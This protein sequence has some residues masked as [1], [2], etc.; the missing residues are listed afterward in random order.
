[1]PTRTTHFI[2]N[3]WLSGSSQPL[4]SR[5]PLTQEILWQGESASEIEVNAAVSSASTACE[6]W[7]NCPLHQRIAYLERFRNEL[8]AASNSLAEAISKEIGKP[9]WESKTEVQAMINKI[10]ISIE[11]YHQRCPE[12]VKENPTGTS[13]TRHKPHGILAIFGPFNFPG[14]LPNGHIIPG[15]LAGNTIIFK[16]SEKAPLVAEITMHCWQKADLPP[17]VINMIQGGRE[18]GTLLS[19]HPGIDGLC[20]TGSWETGCFL[21]EAFAKHPDKILALEM[22]GNNPLV[23]TNVTNIEA[24]VYTIIQ[25]AYLTAGQ[26]CSCARR[27]IILEGSQGDRLVEELIKS[28]QKIRVGPYTDNPEPFM[29]PVISQNA[30]H[31]LLSAQSALKKE[32][33]VPLCEMKLMKVDT[34]LLTPGLIDVTAVS[35]SFDQEIFGPLLQLRRVRDFDAAIIEANKTAY[36]LT[37]GLLSDQEDEFREFYRRVRAGVINW[38]VPLTGAS[39][40]APFGGVGKSGNHRPSGFYAADYCS[41]PVASIEMAELKMPGTMP[42]GMT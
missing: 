11:A 10:P 14:H 41:Y 21:S 39:S 37:A 7:A 2:N 23:V 4:I 28:I 3:Q 13:I 6:N 25:S 1:M 8:S 40:A 27:L 19:K 15:L 16:P 31:Q 12:I 20:F 32:G 29:G 24:A 22:G 26:R 17:G 9:L 5:N 35:K 42:P 38:N 18:T 30:M 34:S 36:G 33:G